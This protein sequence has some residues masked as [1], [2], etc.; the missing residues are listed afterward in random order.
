MSGLTQSPGYSKAFAQALHFARSPGQGLVAEMSFP[1]RTETGGGSENPMPE[2]TVFG[3]PRSTFVQIV[4]LILTH[5][6][7]PYTFRDLE[8]EM[9]TP[10]HL[11]LHP[12]DRVP[13]LQN[14][15]FT[16]Y[17]TSAIAAYLE[18]TF[19]TPALQPDTPRGRAR[20]NQ[21]I[22]A[23]NS[24]F[25]P[26]MIYHVSHERN[27]F[28][29]LGIPSDEAVV[30]HAM[31]KIEVALQVMERE[32]SHGKEYLLG[33]EVSLADYYLL[34]S[35]YAFGLAPEGQALYPKFPRICDWR[36]QMEALPTVQRFRA[37]QPPRAPIE[38][39]RKWAISHR[40]KY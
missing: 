6:E 4:R 30:A 21:W 32:L 19:P 34:P 11:A 23:V 39:A 36:E 1:S 40:P 7:V 16:L 37:A 25:Y 3:F 28:P 14:G 10:A 22:S 27:V 12:F 26:Y 29:Q 35:T 31:P 38:H 15:D 24:Y 18:E 8:P 13:I 2:I 17:E 5:K 20:M 33:P 9:G